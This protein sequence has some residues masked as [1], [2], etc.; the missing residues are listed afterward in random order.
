MESQG[1]AAGAWPLRDACSHPG[2]LPA[3]LYGEIHTPALAAAKSFLEPS[4]SGQLAT[5]YTVGVKGCF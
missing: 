3:A 1:G 5:G 2:L 4:A